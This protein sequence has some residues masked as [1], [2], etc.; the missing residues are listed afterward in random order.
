MKRDDFD[1]NVVQLLNLLKKLMKNNPK[2][3]Q[4]SDFFEPN[5]IDK[6]N[7]NVC[8]FNFLPMSPEDMEEFE[9]AYSELLEQDG[10]EE[11]GHA[12]FGWN[13]SDL[14]FLERHGMKF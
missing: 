11:H 13:Q 14:D 1:K 2:G 12:E 5:Q 8:F 7:L 6:I 10:V 3:A 4:F 9:E